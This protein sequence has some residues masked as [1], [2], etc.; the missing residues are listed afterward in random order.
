MQTPELKLTDQQ[1]LV[2]NHDRGA[3]LVFAVAGA[4]KTTAMVQRI[5]RLVREGV[6]SAETILATSFG[7]SN[8]RDLRRALTP[9]PHCARVNVSTLHALANDIVRTAQARGLLRRPTREVDMGRLDHTILNIAMAEVRSRNL[10]FRHELN[11][12]DRQD[13]LDYVGH[14][15]SNLA[16]AELGRVSL[17]ASARTLA[18]QAEP[19][20]TTL[21][22]YLKLYQIYENIRTKNGWITFDDMLMTGWELLHRHDELLATFQNK[23]E[24]VLVDEFQDINLAQSEILD[25][26][27]FEHR[28][29]MAIG[30]DD[31]TIYEWRG[32]HPRYILDFPQRYNARSFIIS[33][34][35][36]CPATPLVVANRVIKQNKQRQR[37]QLNLTK[38][39]GGK[40][41]LHVNK[42]VD[43][44]ACEIVANIQQL[45][46][47]GRSL[48]D[49]AVLVRLNAQTPP[50]EQKLIEAQIPYRVS[51]PFYERPEIRVLVA[52][53]RLGWLE[54]RLR[55]GKPLSPK[56]REVWEES[57]SLVHNRPKRYINRELRQSIPTAV[58]KHNRPLADVLF[59]LAEG[60]DKVYLADK[61]EQFA[62][63]IAWLADQMDLPAS[64][65]LKMLDSDL[66][67]SNYLR[68][69]T[70]SLQMG[71]SRAI[72]VLAFID[73]AKGKGSL[74]QFMQHI[75]QLGEEKIGRNNPS[76]SVVTLSTIH[77]SKGL[78]WPIVIV[79]NC[80]Q[81]IV[82]FTEMFAA[83]LDYQAHMEEERRL[84]YVAVT[85]TRE[86]LHMYLLKGEMP[87]QFIDEAHLQ[88]TL[89]LLDKLKTALN[90]DIADWRKQ[91]AVAARDCQTVIRHANWLGLERY[92]QHYW[93]DEERLQ[94]IG[95]FLRTAERLDALKQL[96]ITSSQARFWLGIT[97]DEVGNFVGVERLLKQKRYPTPA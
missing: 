53:A 72:S 39:F 49:M 75:K 82:P 73:Y 40:T 68:E 25:L 89:S 48:D 45:H 77:Q 71:E 30:D 56:L 61:L 70:S 6:F 66:G 92:F 43:E 59:N 1:Q 37:K 14:C 62:D 87:S 78:E 69:S 26:L 20:S 47:E 18:K 52:Y 28:N 42:S 41:V 64:D 2:V 32:A 95:R 13:F 4:G 17:P 55:S 51:K 19:P 74:L 8:E 80:N 91:G 24:C 84:F 90:R 36:R 3:A 57:W 5:E 21:D 76:G 86:Q 35:F 81:G 23:F 38:G 63:T 93:H 10:S 44:M 97:P 12:I 94:I 96:S 34:N 67:Y 31:Q 16:Y 15:K 60:T 54:S 50:I 85:R 79:P 22:W 46:A 33:D 88:A 58:L 29:Y 11:G 83:Q 9:H 65:T 27:T 7:K